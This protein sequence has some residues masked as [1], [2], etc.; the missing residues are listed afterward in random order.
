MGTA[1]LGAQ[2][3]DIAAAWLERHG[4]TIVDRNWRCAR[5]EV[6]IVARCADGL[7]FVEVKTRSGATAG[8]PLEAITRTKLRRLRQL[9]PAWFA[10]H[11][12]HAAPQIRI[13]A[14]A[15]HLI[16]PRAVVEHVEAIV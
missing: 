10:A 15:V 4:Y 2:G 16:G 13:D 14:M 3:E 9:V 8:H 6:D 1:E 12:D 5:G 7:V 11:P